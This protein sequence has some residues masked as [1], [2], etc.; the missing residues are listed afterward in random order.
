MDDSHQGETQLDQSWHGLQRSTRK[1]VLKPSHLPVEVVG[2]PEL[3]DGHLTLFV[4]LLYE[5]T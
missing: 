1:A 4:E 5:P 3:L 2:L